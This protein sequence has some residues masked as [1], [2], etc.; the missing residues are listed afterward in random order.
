MTVAGMISPTSA[1]FSTRQYVGLPSQP[2]SVLPSKIDR[3]PASSPLIGSGRSLCFGTYGACCGSPPRTAAS[4]SARMIP[5]IDREMLMC[6]LRSGLTLLHP[7]R[8]AF[9]MLK[10]VLVACCAVLASAMW[11]S[12]QPPRTESSIVLFEGARLIL[13]DAAPPIE[14]GALVVENGRITAVGRRE[15]VKPPRGA[16]RVDLAGKTVMPAMINAHVHIGYEGYTS[17]GASNYTADN[18]LDHLQ[19]E[20]FYGVGAT[21]SV[22][23]SPTAAALQFEKDQRA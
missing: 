10:R 15:D 5:A 9:A 12:A 22:G 16:V 23:S 21:Q 14:A 18:V 11:L 17:W 19:R 6:W 3:N 8:G 20:A 4:P 13:G 1:P 2:A 7:D